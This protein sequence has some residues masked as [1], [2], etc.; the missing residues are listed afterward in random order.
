MTN[1]TN[2]VHQKNLNRYNDVAVVNY[3]SHLQELE[4]YEK[5]LFEKYVPKGASVLDIGV[6]GGGRA[7]PWL[8]A[9]AGSYL[10]IDYASAMVDACRSRFPHQRFM[11]MDATDLSEIASGSID[12]VV[13]SFNGIDRIQPTENRT[14]CLREAIGLLAPSGLFIF[15]EHNAR[16]VIVKPK[17]HDVGLPKRFMANP[18]LGRIDS[19]PG[20]RRM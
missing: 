20:Y 8:A 15:S 7:T 16:Q 9:R 13:F 10:G 19:W 17:L 4:P 14:K 5:G 11:Q 2:S 6:G 1:Q 18:S 12:V 3:Y